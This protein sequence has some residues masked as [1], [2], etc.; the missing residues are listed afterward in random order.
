LSVAALAAPYATLPMYFCAAQ[1]EMF[2]I[3]PLFC[4]TIN[5]A[6]SWLAT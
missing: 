6:A 3:N 1:N 4:F 2:T 5:G